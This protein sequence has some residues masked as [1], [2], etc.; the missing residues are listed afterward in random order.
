MSEDFMKCPGLRPHGASF[1][2]KVRVPAD[3]ASHFPSAY[4]THKVS[5]TDPRRAHA[6]GFAKLAEWSAEYDRIRTTGSQYK[7]SITDAELSHLT[8]LMLHSSLLADEERREAGDYADDHIYQQALQ[9]LDE[10]TTESRQELARGAFALSED[11]ARDWLGAHGYDIPEDSPEYRRAVMAF[12][13]ARAQKLKMQRERMAGEWIDTP[14]AP[15]APQKAQKEPPQAHG[16]T[17]SEVVAEFLKRPRQHREMADVYQSVMPVFLEVVGDK[18]VSALL[19][20]DI[21]DFF[22][23]L[24][25]LPPRWDLEKARRGAGLR[26]LAAMEWPKCLAPKTVKARYMATIRKFLS[27]SVRIYR[28]QGFPTHLTIEGIEYSGTRK[29]RERQQRAMTTEELVRLFNGPEYQDFA[30]DPAQAHRYWLPLLGLFTG[31]RI[32]ELCQLNPQ[33]D[34]R[35]EDGI[36]FIDITDEGEGDSAI[37]RTVK[38]ES[39]RRRVPL[40]SELLRLGFLRYVERV[41]AAGHK[42]LFPGFPPKGDKASGTAKVWFRKLLASTGLRDTTHRAALVGFHC[43]RSNFLNRAMNQGELLAHW[44]TGHTDGQVSQVVRGYRGTLELKKKQEILERITFDLV[45]L[46]HSHEGPAESPAGPAGAADRKTASEP[47]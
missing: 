5:E 2:L 1:Q 4:R 42:L 16:L 36:A 28:D 45:P 24:C 21:E 37:V 10:D 23:L 29:D 27:E 18:P 17:L 34:I 43:F 25:K 47:L 15:A 35:E 9:V 19:Q 20:K 33:Q 46:M 7:T 6:A 41:K 31:A 14:P 30:A 44:L 26:E 32:N 13:K 8:A 11:I 12:A 22:L 3:V 38:T 39:S 40:H